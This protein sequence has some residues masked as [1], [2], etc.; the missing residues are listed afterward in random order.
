MRSLLAALSVAV[1][2][3][4]PARGAAETFRAS[5]TSRDGSV[6]V[7]WSVK[8]GHELEV[9][10]DPPKKKGAYRERR[11]VGV[12]HLHAD[13][14]DANGD[15]RP[16]VILRYE[17][18]RGYSPDVLVNRD[19]LSFVHA[20]QVKEGLLVE[21]EPATVPPK[22]FELGRWRLVSGPGRPT[23]LVFEN[24]VVGKRRYRDA[25]FRLDARTLKYQLV[26]KGAAL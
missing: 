22:A 25:T 11:E 15:G 9:S 21:A 8:D 12:G 2:A 5:T 26:A 20:L 10:I 17:D 3:L 13:F 24:V 7:S 16:D 19:D 23:E 14:L 6:V 1:A 4:V 18:Q